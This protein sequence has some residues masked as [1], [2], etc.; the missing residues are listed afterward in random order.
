LQ[1]QEMIIP[2]QVDGGISRHSERNKVKSRN[3]PTLRSWKI[4]PRASERLTFLRLVGMTFLS[5]TL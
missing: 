2:R 4:P 5:S 3:P 1:L